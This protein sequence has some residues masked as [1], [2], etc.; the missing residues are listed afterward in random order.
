VKPSGNWWNKNLYRRMLVSRLGILSVSLIIMGAGAFFIAQTALR[1][2]VHQ[3]NQQMAALAAKDIN[4]QLNNIWANLRLFSNEMNEVDSTL[5]GQA[6]AMLEFRRGSP[7]DYRAAYLFDGQDQLIIHLAETPEDLAAIQNPSIIATRAPIA[8]GPEIL[9]AAQAAN[10]NEYYISS[11]YFGSDRVPLIDVGFPIQGRQDLLQQALVVSVDLHKI[12]QRVDEISRGRPWRSYV[13]SRQGVIIAHPDRAYVSLGVPAEIRPVLAGLEGT[14]QYPDLLSGRTL[15]AAF[16]PVGEPA[17]WGVVVEQDRDQALTSISPIAYMTPAIL[18]LAAGLVGL[19]TLH[20]ARSITQPIEDL[21]KATQKIAKTGSLEEDIAYQGEDEVAQLASNFNHMVATM[22]VA[23]ARLK[24][25]AAQLSLLNDIGRKLSALTAL[26]DSLDRATHLLQKSFGYYH[27]AIY[28]LDQQTNELV[29][30]SKAGAYETFLADDL[31]L[32]RGPGIISWVVD[33]MESVVINDV[34]S[35]PRYYNC[36][37][38]DIQTRAELCVPIGIG[39]IAAGAVD[40]QSPDPNAFDENDLMVMETLADQLAA[41]MENARLYLAVRQE[42]AERRRAETALRKSEERYA[43]AAAGAN[44]GLWDWDLATNQVYYSPRWKNMLG[45]EENEI[46]ESLEDWYSRVHPEDIEQ[47]RTDLQNHLGGASHN[48][49]NEH[50]IQNRSGAYRWVLSRGIAIRDSQGTPYRVAGSMSDITERKY[51]EQ[52]L[53]FDALHDALTGLPNRALFLDRLELDIRRARRYADQQFAVIFLDLD[54]FKVINDSLGHIAGDHLLVAISKRLAD[55]IRPS[56][57]IARLGGDEFVLILEGLQVLDS[58]IQVADRILAQMTLPFTIDQH[59]LVISASIGVVWSGIG[60]QRPEEVLRDADIAMYQAK[61]S[62]K[63]RYQVFDTSMR[64]ASLARLKLEADLRRALDRQEFRVFYQPILAIQSGRMVGFEALLRWDA[65]DLGLVLPEGFIQVAEES[66]LIVPI[67]RWVLRESCWA[68]AEWNR[69]YRPEEPIVIN[70]NLSGKQFSRGEIASYITEILADSGLSPT[71]LQ[72]EIT[73]SVVIENV[74]FTTSVLKQLRQQ[75]VQAAIDDFGTG[76][77]SLSYLFQLPVS[78][79]KIDRSFIS[80][81]DQDESQAEIVQ[82]IITLAHNL[83]MQVTAEGVET[84]AQLERLKMQGCDCCQGYLISA[85]LDR[86]AAET[87][88]RHHS[89]LPVASAP[90]HPRPA[91]FLNDPKVG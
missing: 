69:L 88:L 29:L 25:R 22:R 60:Y 54:S 6:R 91:A 14:T 62:G 63:A 3:R 85:P 1:E 24:R 10:R 78:G 11:V 90:P 71:C 50:R 47:L 44:D 83:G 82:A 26:D 16:S 61:G 66:Q 32:K 21:V 2:E 13:L 48:F 8:V 28:F 55:C 74:E 42:L 12:W 75:G 81:L 89:G 53:M 56:D 5:A 27:V 67:D 87:F 77:S 57:T 39:G 43:L 37:P 76:Y 59:D 20:M 52:R 9:A 35:D 36:D 70:V 80:R 4:A 34:L 64:Q 30:K 84:P 65:P 46:G 19:L 31:R 15:L 49:E 51:T 79:L 23:D 38:D 18:L 86:L 58:A 7:L 68:V 72:V 41:A 33:H 45:C 17:G 73:E 40:V